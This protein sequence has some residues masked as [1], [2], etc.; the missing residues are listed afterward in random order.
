[1]HG[2]AKI[3]PETTTATPLATSSLLGAK[4]EQDLIGQARCSVKMGYLQEGTNYRNTLNFWL[5]K[6]KSALYLS[7]TVYTASF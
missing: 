7:K 3:C 2:S 5:G 6:T 1:M 4:H